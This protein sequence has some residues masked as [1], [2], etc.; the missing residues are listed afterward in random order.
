MTVP[1]APIPDGVV[2]QVSTVPVS[3]LPTVPSVSACVRT[4]AAPRTS[5]VTLARAAPVESIGA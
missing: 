5:S 4:V 3:A 2:D 1:V